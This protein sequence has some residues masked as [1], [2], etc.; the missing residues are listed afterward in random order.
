[1]DSDDT[2]SDRENWRDDVLL[3]QLGLNPVDQF[4]TVLVDLVVRLVEVAPLGGSGG[5]EGLDDPLHLQFLGKRPGESGRLA[6]PPALAA[7]VLAL[8]LP[9]RPQIV[10][11]KV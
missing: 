1:M 5:F 8:A 10:A 6:G 3:L 7:A 2:P 4:V 11:P 9:N